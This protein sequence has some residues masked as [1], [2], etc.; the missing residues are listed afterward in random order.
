MAA[1]SYRLLYSHYDMLE[2]LY[3]VL[4]V[5]LAVLQLP[6]AGLVTLQCNASR[7]STTSN[8]NLNHQSQQRAE[9]TPALKHVKA[10]LPAP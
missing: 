6:H 8:G 2:R 10:L 9:S 3:S 7:V 1:V 5:V 4:S